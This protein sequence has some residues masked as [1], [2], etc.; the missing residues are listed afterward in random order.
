[1]FS[2]FSCVL[3]VHNLFRATELTT[4]YSLVCNNGLDMCYVNSCL[5][6]ILT[7]CSRL[8]LFVNDS[9]IFLCLF[10]CFMPAIETKVHWHGEIKNKKLIECHMPMKWILFV[11][12]GNI[13]CKTI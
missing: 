3:C 1:M 11:P 4:F 12:L 9:A 2:L 5:C 8:K 7:K 13:V 6:H 10:A